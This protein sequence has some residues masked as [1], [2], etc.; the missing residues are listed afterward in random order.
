MNILSEVKNQIFFRKIKNFLLTTILIVFM[1]LFL[2]ILQINSDN[3]LLNLDP[4]SLLITFF[5]LG[6][7]YLIFREK[8]IKISH[9]LLYISH[10]PNKYNKFVQKLL[11]KY[12]LSILITNI[13]LIEKVL[14][15]KDW[16]LKSI[17]QNTKLEYLKSKEF[18]KYLN[19]FDYSTIE[20][21]FKEEIN[22]MEFE[23]NNEYSYFIKLIKRKKL[24]LEHELKQNTLPEAGITIVKGIGS[25]EII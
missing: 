22:L 21:Y 11:L 10:N 8:E 17:N 15:Q 1:L 2:N 6:I 14:N 16:L 18:V 25:V 4:I 23:I 9:L 5:V 13:D 7:F 3:I 20:Y 19:K 12:E 24:S